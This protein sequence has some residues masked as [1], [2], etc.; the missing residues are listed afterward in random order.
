[1]TGKSTDVTQA[2]RPRTVTTGWQCRP[3]ERQLVGD[4]GGA[5]V[6]HERDEIAQP[7]FLHPELITQA[8]A[9]GDVSV[10]GGSEGTHDTPSGQTALNLRRVSRSTFA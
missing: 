10:K 9:H 2:Q 7:T 3:L 1:M 5:A 4:D 6:L 8:A